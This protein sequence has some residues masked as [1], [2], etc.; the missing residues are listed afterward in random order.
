MH[1]LVQVWLW[2]FTFYS[3]VDGV[4]L[5][6]C[7]VGFGV[8][9]CIVCLAEEEG[10]A[11]GRKERMDGSKKREEEGGKEGEKKEM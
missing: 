6:L 1:S 9:N 5:L 4:N 3:S 8:L 11:N 2:L 10:G 7:V